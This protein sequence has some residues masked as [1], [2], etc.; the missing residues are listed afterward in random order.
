VV[1]GFELLR[2]G[3]SAA[4]MFDGARA[5]DPVEVVAAR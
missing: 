2:R 1:T 4:A 5:G 3:G